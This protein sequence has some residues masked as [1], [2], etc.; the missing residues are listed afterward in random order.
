[1]ALVLLLLL[2][3]LC[4][5]KWRR[6]G[7]AIVFQ[8]HEVK[9]FVVSEDPNPSSSTRQSSFATSTSKNASPGATT[10]DYHPPSAVGK[11][12]TA[13]QTL[14]PALAPSP[15]QIP[16]TATTTNSA[17]YT[18]AGDSSSRIVMRQDSGMR[19]PQQGPDLVEYPPIYPG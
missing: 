9:P 10:R 8:T 11:Q 3:I 1:M 7:P 4:Y 6:R 2:G 17:S 14:A 18:F 13:C 15:H 12:A 19:L 16:S 5:R